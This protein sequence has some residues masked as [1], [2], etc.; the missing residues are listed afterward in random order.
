MFI[1]YQNKINVAV[2]VDSEAR[3]QTESLRLINL[4]WMGFTMGMYF[5]QVMLI[6]VCSLLVFT[7]N[8]QKSISYALT[9]MSAHMERRERSCLSSCCPYGWKQPHRSQQDDLI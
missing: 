5:C 1:L 7:T 4:L 6:D 2:I 8:M 9:G 3:L